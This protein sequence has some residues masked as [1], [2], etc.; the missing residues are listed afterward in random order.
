MPASPASAP[1]A[2]G[3]RR[4]TASSEGDMSDGRSRLERPKGGRFERLHPVFPSRLGHP[5]WDADLDSIEVLKRFKKGRK[6]G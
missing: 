3:S 5:L 1:S 4:C 2:N 6:L